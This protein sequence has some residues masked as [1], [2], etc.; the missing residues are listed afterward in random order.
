MAIPGA[1]GGGRPRKS[2]SDCVRDYLH[3]SGLGY[4]DP[5]NRRVWKSG[6]RRSSCLLPTP[7]TG[8]NPAADDK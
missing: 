8:T 3:T 6:V 1:R 7:A 2:L 4:I 5:Q